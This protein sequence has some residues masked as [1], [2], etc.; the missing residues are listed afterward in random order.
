MCNICKLRSMTNF[1]FIALLLPKMLEN[2]ESQLYSV[3]PPQSYS[4][5][6]GAALAL[7]HQEQAP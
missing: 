5:K 1:F 3:S 4:K 6:E 2:Q 7:G